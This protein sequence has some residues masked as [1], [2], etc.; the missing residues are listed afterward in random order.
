M[1]IENR[2]ESL[3]MTVW[4]KCSGKRKQ[5]SLRPYS[6]GRPGTGTRAIGSRPEIVA[7]NARASMTEPLHRLHSSC[8]LASRRF[9]RRVL[10]MRGCTRH[11]QLLRQR[12]F[13]R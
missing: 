2:N 6:G 5:P 8:G 1:S 12:R 7:V 3:L 13:D 11:N 4:I 10:V 9:D